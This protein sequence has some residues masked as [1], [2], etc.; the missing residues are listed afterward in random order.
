MELSSPGTMS[1]RLSAARNFETKRRCCSR[2]LGWRATAR[3]P[4]GS[5]PPRRFFSAVKIARRA[6]I[7]AVA[8]K[9][10]TCPDPCRSKKLPE[11]LLKNNF[12]RNGELNSQRLAPRRSAT[13]FL[14][15]SLVARNFPEFSCLIQGSRWVS[16]KIRN[17]S[18]PEICVRF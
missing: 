12:V 15:A 10:H 7:R 9:L 2:N 13:M 3:P 1:K 4:C 8:D 16:L 5:P 11:R 14:P 18:N 17:Q 6:D